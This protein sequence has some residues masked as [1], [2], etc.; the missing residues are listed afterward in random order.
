VEAGIDVA[1]AGTTTICIERPAGRGAAAERLGDPSNPFLATIGL[2]VEPGP[3]GSGVDVRLAVGVEAIPVYVFKTVDAFREAMTENVAATLHEGL[4]GWEVRD[5]VVTMTDCACTSPGTTAAD[6]RKLTPRVLGAAL[7][8]AGTVVCEPIHRLRLDVPADT[9]SAV[10][11]VLARC[12]AMPHAPVTSGG[13]CTVEGLIPAAE[14]H[15]LQRALGGR[16]RG[17][18]VLESHFDRYAPAPPGVARPR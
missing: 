2:A 13:W 14:I 4:A 5:C 15:R 8:R 10:L 12:R 9:P 1:F 16:T 3:A 17:A 7:R 18:G 11:R 6:F